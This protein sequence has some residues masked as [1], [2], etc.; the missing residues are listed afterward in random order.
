MLAVSVGV[1]VPELTP[2]PHSF[3]VRRWADP[4]VER[5]G[6]PVSSLYTETVLLPVLGPST[7]L[8][9]RRLGGWATAFPNGT[10]VDTGRL[11]RDLGLSDSLA[12]NSPMSRT[13]TRL[14]RFGMARWVGG[15]LAVRTKVAPL[16]TSAAAA[17]TADG[18]CSSPAGPPPVDGGTGPCVFVG[19]RGSGG[20]TVGGVGGAVV[21]A[22]AG[23]AGPRSGRGVGV[24]VA[25]SGFDPA[26]GGAGGQAEGVG[27]HRGRQLTGEVDQ[28]GGP[29]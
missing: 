11:A 28:H 22:V 24:P 4:V 8:C 15:E 7:T 16:G 3:V 20:G 26:H 13:L 17:V 1:F 21:I 6:F 25:A 29:G 12:S 18:R 10:G 5:A 14:C 19:E 2:L 9:L 27:D 23:S